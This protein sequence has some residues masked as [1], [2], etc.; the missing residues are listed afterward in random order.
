M[1]PSQLPVQVH[2]QVEA[3]GAERTCVKSWNMDSLLFFS[4]IASAMAPATGI[5]SVE[6]PLATGC[7]GSPRR[8]SLRRLRKI[9]KAHRVTFGLVLEQT[10]VGGPTVESKD[11]VSERTGSKAQRKA[12]QTCRRVGKGSASGETTLKPVLYSLSTKSLHVDYTKI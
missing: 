8:T 9:L 10:R 3:T 6:T 7:G 12:L 5:F 2:V 11:T 4:R 1:R